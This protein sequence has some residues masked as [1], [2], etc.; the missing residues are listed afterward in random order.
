MI[1]KI[2][3]KLMEHDKRFDKIDTPFEIIKKMQ[4]DIE[5]QQKEIIKIKQ[6]LKIA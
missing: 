6:I 2:F 1:E 3:E 5:N 4:Q